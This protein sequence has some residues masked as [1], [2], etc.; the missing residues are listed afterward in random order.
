MNP[1]QTPPALSIP[2]SW[3]ENLCVSVAKSIRTRRIDLV[4]GETWLIHQPDKRNGKQ[5][6]DANKQSGKKPDLLLMFG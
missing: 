2:T 6:A 1:A 5:G 4:R 3:C